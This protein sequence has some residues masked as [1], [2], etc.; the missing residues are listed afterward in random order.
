MNEWDFTRIYKDREAF[1]AA[2]AAL[3]NEI[4]RYDSFKGTITDKESLLAYLE[5]DEKIGGEF[6]KIYTY[7]S[8]YYDQYQKAPERQEVYAEANDLYG[9][10]VQAMS[11]GASEIIALGEDKVKSY[12]AED[13]RLKRFAYPLEKIFHSRQHIFDPRSEELMANYVQATSNYNRLYDQLA[14]ADGHPV[15]VTLTDGK[16]VEVNQ[17]N[18]R[19]YL[20]TLA[21]QEDRRLVFE[22]IFKYFAEHRNTFAGIY[23]GII[24]SD[25]AEARNR[26]Y[27]T[28]LESYLFGNN[29]PESVFLSLI[30]TVRQN[31]GP[32]KEYY[33][34]RQSHFKLETLHTYDRFL[35]FAASE[36]SYTYEEARDLFLTAA[37]RLGPEFE[38]LA[39]QVLEPGRVDVYPKDGK[40]T[41]AY[42]TGYYKEG[43][44]ILLNHSGTLDDCFTVAHEAG[45][46]IHTALANASQPLATADYTIFV[47]EIA[48]TFDE[49]LL[50]DHLLS[51]TDDKATRLVLLQ[52]AI[53]GLIATFYRQTLFADYEYRAHKLAEEGKPVTVENLSAI[54]KEL[55]LTYYGIYLE[56]EPYKEFVWAYIPHFFHSPFYVYQY[57]TCY[58]ASLAIYERVKSGAEEALDDYLQM[59]K[60]GGSDYPVEIVRRGGVDLTTDKPFL[61]V[62][63]RFEELL[64]ALKKELD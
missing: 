38:A 55:Y 9:R 43:P 1:E 27:G 41:G 46:S 32:L 58:A 49:Q 14:V 5:F 57:A 22:A 52:S 39:G 59:L 60:A 29:I 21:S 4:G 3:S 17:S 8:M 53:D 16:T 54:M 18:Y 12:L 47:A 42:S 33:A 19:N 23:N 25:L 35:Q 11:F 40:R 26:R 44:F 24:Q 56:S 50:L 48:S 62:V 45:H 31:T 10:L 7:A 37:K 30:D 15:T 63:K 64:A 2:L 36:R 20:Q 13:D 34:L 6:S 51:T 28:I 61:A